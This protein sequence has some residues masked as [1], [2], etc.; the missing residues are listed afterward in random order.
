M[1]VSIFKRP[2]LIVSDPSRCSPEKAKE[3]IG[4]IDRVH[5]L[6][7]HVP[8]L[9]TDLQIAT[10]LALRELLFD[11]MLNDDAHFSVV[12]VCI[13]KIRA[14]KLLLRPFRLVASGFSTTGSE[15][16]F[17]LLIELGKFHPDGAVDHQRM[18]NGTVED[19]SCR[20]GRSKFTAGMSRRA[21]A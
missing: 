10:I 16:A 18:L 17:F 14:N 21:N 7:L 9:V 11:T 6:S 13:Y 1:L 2:P 20:A 19:S 5:E 8:D 4:T 15:S 12:C 3:V